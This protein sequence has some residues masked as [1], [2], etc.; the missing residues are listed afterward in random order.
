VLDNAILASFLLALNDHIEGLFN[1]AGVPENRN[2]DGVG[3]LFGDYD[4]AQVQTRPRGSTTSRVW[5]R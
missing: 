2:I 5:R 1:L 4:K 3:F